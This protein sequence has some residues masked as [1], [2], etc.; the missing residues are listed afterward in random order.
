LFELTVV[1][2]QN[3]D[4]AL[5]LWKAGVNV[6][7]GYEGDTV[8]RFHEHCGWGR[9]EGNLEEVK[10]LIEEEGVCLFKEE[11]CCSEIPL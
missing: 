11:Y 2:R 10:K 8:R 6:T 1:K 3:W 5:G 7:R 9:K 4:E